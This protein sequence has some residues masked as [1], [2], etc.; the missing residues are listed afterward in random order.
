MDRYRADLEARLDRC[1]E[2][3]GRAR[4]GV[5]ALAGDGRTSGKEEPPEGGT[6]IMIA[7]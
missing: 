5:P 1:L 3:D 4:V 7:G 2:E 6:G